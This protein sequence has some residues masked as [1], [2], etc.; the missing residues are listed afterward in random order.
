MAAGL[1]RL[2]KERD[3]SSKSDIILSN[4]ISVLHLDI[5]KKVPGQKQTFNGGLY[6]HLR[7]HSFWTARR[8]L[9][10]DPSCP[11]NLLDSLLTGRG[12]GTYDISLF[13]K[14]N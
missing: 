6:C 13:L 1:T 14:I 10:T 9:S 12:E 3:T 8:D 5:R 4:K 11:F 2:V 7:H